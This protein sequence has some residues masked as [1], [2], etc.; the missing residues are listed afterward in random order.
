MIYLFR[1]AKGLL[2]SQICLGLSLSALF[3]GGE[4]RDVNGAT[5]V[6]LWGIYEERIPRIQG[7]KKREARRITP[8]GP[9]LLIFR[10]T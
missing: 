6:Y 3:L 1:G 4:L 8:T 7:G 10:L 5:L 2:Q 9:A